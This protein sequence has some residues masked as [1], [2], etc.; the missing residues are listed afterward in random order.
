MFSWTKLQTP[1]IP[2]FVIVMLSG[3]A[4]SGKD[5]AAAL[6]AEEHQFIRVAFADALKVD[7]SEATGLPVTLFHSWA[8]DSPLPEPIDAF[9]QAQ[10]PRDLLLAHAL[11]QRALNPDIFSQRII[12]HIREHQRYQD[13]FVVSDWRY[14]REYDHMMEEFPAA[15][16]VRVRVTRKGVTQ[17]DDPTEHDLD[18]APIDLTIANDGCISDLR[19]AL[20]HGLRPWL[21]RD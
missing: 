1:M 19:D 9:P 17:T 14:Q 8:K 15:S 3:W 7:V 13:R 5:A 2:P 21:H 11:E 18:G 12:D 10:T 4:G 16:I 20:R 6:L